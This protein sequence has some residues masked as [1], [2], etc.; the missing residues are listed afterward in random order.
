MTFQF[1]DNR[2]GAARH[3]TAEFHRYRDSNNVAIQLIGEDG[4][5]WCMATVN[6]PD[7][8]LEDGVVAIKTYS[9]NRGIDAFLVSAGI[10]EAI[11]VRHIDNLGT[12]YIRI[13]VY[14]LTPAALK[15]AACAY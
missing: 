5:P 3:M 12:G 1:I 7:E 6:V 13:P 14:R 9:E 10:I 8:I 15:E 11:P 2:D 4:M